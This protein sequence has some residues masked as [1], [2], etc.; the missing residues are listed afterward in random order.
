MNEQKQ[1]EACARLEG[2]EVQDGKVNKYIPYRIQPIRYELPTYDS[3][4][5]LRRILKTMRLSELRKY[6]KFLMEI[7]ERDNNKP[8]IDGQDVIAEAHQERESLLK[9]K[10]LWEATK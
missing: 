4:D 8:F 6:K 10:G 1:K 5:D 7:I 2:L 9:V 3:H